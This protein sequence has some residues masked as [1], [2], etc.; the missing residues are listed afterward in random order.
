MTKLDK[1]SVSSWADL[2][3]RLTECSPD[4]LRVIEYILE[5]IEHGRRVYGPMNLA[6]DKRDLA[7]EAAQES[8]DWLTYR[9]MLAIQR[10]DR[11]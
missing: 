2:A 11:G 1:A 7:D 8:R 10:R 3:S 6:T 5:G 9:A 4:E